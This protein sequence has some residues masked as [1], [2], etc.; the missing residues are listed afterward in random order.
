MDWTQTQS[1][2]LD[3]IE[4]LAH[5]AFAGLPAEF[6]A[7]VTQ[8]VFRIEDFPDED[9]IRAMALES[10]FDILGLFHGATLA[11]HEAGRVHGSQTMIFL[12]RR[13]ILDYWAEHE[14]ALGTIVRH[15]LIHEIGHHFGLSDDD[16]DAIEEAAG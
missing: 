3:D 5:A 11:D 4:A 13:P 14:E 9:V 7:R 6:R 16:M 8:V 2:S 10:E 15:V 1:P 12:Y